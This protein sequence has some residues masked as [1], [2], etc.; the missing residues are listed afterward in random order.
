MD[1]VIQGLEYRVALAYIDDIIV[2]ARDIDGCIDNMQL[3]LERLRNANLK[4]KAKK[5]ILFAH[6][7]EYLGHVITSTGVKTDPKKIEAVKEWHP[8]ALLVRYDRSW[9][10]QLIIT[11]SSRTLLKLRNHLPN[12]PN[13]LLSF[14]GRTPINRLSTGYVSY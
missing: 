6:E 11:G 2:Y 4:L 7:V 13:E 14:T 10:S 8:P 3:V 12:S 1:R 5:C 9:A